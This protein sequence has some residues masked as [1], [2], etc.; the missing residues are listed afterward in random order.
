MRWLLMLFLLIFGVGSVSAQSS[1]APRI[2]RFNGEFTAINRDE[3]RGGEVQMAVN[4]EVINRPMTATLVFE[5]VFPNGRVVNVEL[6]RPFPWVNSSGSGI[7][8]LVYPGD[9]LITDTLLVRL[10]VVN[11]LTQQT[12]TQRELTI[13]VIDIS[14]P[15]IS[16]FWSDNTV[17]ITEE[18]LDGTSRVRVNWEVINRTPE[19]NLAFEQVLNDGSVVNVELPRPDIWVNSVGS[20][21]V[22]PVSP[23][24][25]ATLVEL[26]VRLYMVA[27]NETIA[28]RTLFL[29]VQNRPVAPT[30]TPTPRPALTIRRFDVTPNQAM[31]GD[32]LTVN[33]DVSGVDEVQVYLSYT[34]MNYNVAPPT[35]A[36]SGT[37]TLIAPQGVREVTV[38]IQDTTP[39]L[40]VERTIP[41]TCSVEWF[42]PNNEY[43]P[44]APPQTIQ[45]AYQAFEHG[46]MIWRQDTE[47]IMIYF[48]DTDTF[49]LR[50]DAYTEGDI[51]FSE[52]PPEGLL[53]P[54]NGFGKIWVEEEG[55]RDRLG[56]AMSAEEGYEMTY[57]ETPWGLGT[58]IS[59]FRMFT[60]PDGTVISDM[61]DD[62]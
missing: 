3:L 39:S 61:I 20:G 33:W 34:G 15:Q 60:L 56:W 42:T 22:A 49:M 50:P 29:P 40:L 35:Y 24:A 18:L 58:R 6:P 2:T 43:C 11:I 47:L 13:A 21:D 28:M 37:V 62:F 12:I 7:V 54:I 57:Q 36:N 46:Y 17:V 30:S 59:R 23:G 53:Q 14:Q 25:G 10:R 27:T 45:A 8:A 16:S 41:L 4:W 5:Q 44:S 52:A 55:I 32:T 9:N 31:G 1:T 38:V 51:T 48:A 19:M 26:R